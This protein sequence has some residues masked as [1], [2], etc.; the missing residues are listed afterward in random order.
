MPNE[1]DKM[2]ERLIKRGMKPS[3][4]AV[5]SERIKKDAA[6]ARQEL[7]ELIKSEIPKKKDELKNLTIDNPI[8][9]FYE[10]FN[11]CR[12]QTLNN[13]SKLFEGIG[14]SGAQAEFAD[15]IIPRLPKLNY[16][17]KDEKYFYTK[18]NTK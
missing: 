13:L 14:L 8:R 2:L 10:G 12:S 15:S 9:K 16:L 4:Q 7:W 18:N 5:Y 17:E 1:I 3:E 6:R 11:Q